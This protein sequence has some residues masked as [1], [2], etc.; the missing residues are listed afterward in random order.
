MAHFFNKQRFEED[1]RD[2]VMD[3]GDIYEVFDIKYKKASYT[4]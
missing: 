4:H 1:L 2:P 3:I